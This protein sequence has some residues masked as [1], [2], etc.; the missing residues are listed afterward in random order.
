MFT[1]CCFFRLVDL[2]EDREAWLHFPRRVRSWGGEPYPTTASDRP[3][4]KVG[5]KKQ[6]ALR[7][8]APTSI[9]PRYILIILWRIHATHFRFIMNYATKL[10]H[11]NSRCGLP[12]VT[13]QHSPESWVRGV[14]DKNCGPFMGQGTRPKT[15]GLDSTPGILSL[16][17]HSSYLTEWVL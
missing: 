6:K 7:H 8:C 17:P 11:F 2:Q 16:V 1:P 10:I 12:L 14:G 9:L 13:W 3:W 15:W 5:G 4:R